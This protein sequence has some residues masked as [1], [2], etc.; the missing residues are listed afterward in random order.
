MTD[1][2]A[3]AKKQPPRECNCYA[4]APENSNLLCNFLIWGSEANAFFS[5]SFDDKNCSQSA[6]D[7][8]FFTHCTSFALDVGA[9]WRGGA[10]LDPTIL[11]VSK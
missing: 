11:F 3:K 8:D 10:P 5:H 4:Y 6:N 2:Q 7:D 9:A 1:S